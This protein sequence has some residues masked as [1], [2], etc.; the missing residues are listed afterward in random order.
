MDSKG[1]E[2]NLVDL[3]NYTYA[4]K[5]QYTQA[6]IDLYYQAIQEQR[7]FMDALGEICDEQNKIIKAIFDIKH[8]QDNVD[9]IEQR[10]LKASIRLHE[11]KHEMDERWGK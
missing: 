11:I 3:K 7:H 8:A 6:D 9:E 4:V 1:N 5:K 10:G 2:G